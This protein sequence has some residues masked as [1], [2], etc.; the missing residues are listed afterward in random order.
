MKDLKARHVS[1]RELVIDDYHGLKV[2]DPYRWLEDDTSPEVQK[3]MEEQNRDFQNFASTYP[4]RDEVKNRIT[5]LWTYPKAGVPRIEGDYY[6]TWRND[7]LQNQS[8][9]YRSKDP[10]EKGEVI[11][12]PNTFSDDGTVAVLTQ[13]YSHAGKYLGYGRSKSGSD[14]ETIYVMDLESKKDTGDVLHH[15]KFSGLTWLP[16]DSGFFYT[17]FPEPKADLAVA[18]DARNAMVYLH[19]LG[20]D[21]K[22]DKLIYKD[23]EHPDWDSNLY[24][25]E[26]GKWAF[27][28]IS[29]GTLF[30]N[31]LFYR[32]LNKIDSPWL[33]ISDTF[34]EGYRVIGVVD[35]TAYIFTQKEAPFGKLMSIKLSEGGPGQWNTVIPDK[36]EMMESARI[37][38]N[39]IICTFLHHASHQLK[40]FDLSGKELGII[41]LP[42][43]GSIFDLSCKQD[44]KEFLIQFSS[45]LYPA[46]IMRYCFTSK[47]LE[48][49]Y[50]PEIDFKF[51]D[52]E[53]IQEFYNSKDG[54]KVPMFITRKKGIKKDGS[55]PTLLYGYGGY[56]INM[57]PGF[58]IRTLAW[59]E[60]GG[61]YAVACIRGGAEYGE[62][63]HRAGMLES[64]QNCFDDFIAAGEYL[65]SE[66]Y[67]AKER[68]AI[69]G[70]SNGGLLTGACVTQRPDLFGAVII[71]VPVLDML[72]YH[73]FTAGRYWTG[74]FGC[75][76]DP[77]QFKFLYKYSP[78]HNVKMSTVYPPILVMTADTDDRVVPSQARKF[79]ATIQAADG[80]ENPILIRIEKSAGHG[81]GKPISKMIAEMTDLFSFLSL[82]IC[83]A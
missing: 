67:T 65:I 63:W 82:T 80:G 58:S 23:D 49:I 22:E 79:T 74:E 35:D 30:K 72:R 55:H 62:A 69:I 61:I 4:K 45:Y 66:K 41:D 83:K 48:T 73:H 68:L 56:N 26:E 64:K 34:E 11:L 46:A 5:K 78:L 60:R 15:M 50:S 57:T 21:Q 77:E 53:T 8:V 12:D 39:E 14:W 25:D 38:N 37:V 31:K 9:L 33:T 6:Y 76:D 47:K 51:D 3:W 18:K 17:R 13:S 2:A 36:G 43:V 81:H 16:D 1:K 20:T 75:A 59:I 19:L 54:T 29:F 10:K 7:G 28:R 71:A 27:L 44:S 70:G 32:P 52:Y 24:S 42:T 40:R